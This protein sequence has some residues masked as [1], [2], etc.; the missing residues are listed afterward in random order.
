MTVHLSGPALEIL[1]RRQADA[2][3]QE[4][5]FPGRRHGK[6]L[7]DP[8]KP[9]KDILA[10][11]GLHDLRLHDLRRTMGSWQ[12]ATGASLPIIGKSLGHLNQGTT[13][14][15]ARLDL[16]PVKDAVDRATSAMLTAGGKADLLLEVHPAPTTGGKRR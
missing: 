6:P 9:W 5:V 7:S 2:D 8:T 14:V 3:G 13:A 15:Y 12:A 11:A 4:F 10:K 1:R 16:D